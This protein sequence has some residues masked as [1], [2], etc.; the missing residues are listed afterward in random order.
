MIGDG[1]FACSWMLDGLAQASAEIDTRRGAR[2]RSL[3]VGPHELLVA[4]TEGVASEF[5]DGLFL[6]APYA[7]RV[8]AARF[9]FDGEVIELPV[10]APPHSAHGVVAGRRWER[11]A[12]G[13]FT[14][15]LGDRWPFGGWA[16]IEIET[17]ATG[18][19]L[20]ARVGAGDRAMPTNIGWHPWF[21]RRVDDI[22]AVLAWD[23]AI[24]YRDDDGI[25]SRSPQPR[26]PAKP[27]WTAPADGQDPVVRWPGLLDLRLSSAEA[28]CWVV[29]ET[30]EA[31]C[32][33]PQT[34]PGNALNA[35]DAIIVR[36]GENTCVDL[37]LTFVPAI[38]GTDGPA[39]RGI[40][41]ASSRPRRRAR[42]HRSVP[43]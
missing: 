36:P 30:A 34:A 22:E 19:R 6:M 27:T 40:R 14:T 29:H 35:G 43:S 1:I 10:N 17:R 9:G 7:G 5:Q 31:I 38:G 37:E 18:L 26:D 15:S 3:R 28:R 4:H 33:E 41:A 13:R 8:A 32:V 21:R 42:P 23:A 20:E 11:L 25:T 39:A 12:P 2:L 16:S 24:S